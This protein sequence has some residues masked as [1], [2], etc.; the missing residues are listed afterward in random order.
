MGHK[1]CFHGILCLQCCFDLL[2]SSEITPPC[3]FLTFSRVLYAYNAAFGEQML[4]FVGRPGPV[5]GIGYEIKQSVLPTAGLS[6][7]FPQSTMVYF[8]FVFAAITLVLIAGSYLCRMNFYAWMLFVPLWLTLSY[9]VG[10]F[11][12]WGG[13]FLFQMGVIDYS[14]GYVIHLSAGTAGFVGAWWIGPRTD[15]D[16]E[17]NQ[18]NNITMMLVGAGILWIGW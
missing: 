16:L 12:L 15:E 9:V 14:G 2:V 8:Q 11:S 7:N 18:P 17:D 6:Q 5:I 13:G 10:A 1:L 3:T 4:P